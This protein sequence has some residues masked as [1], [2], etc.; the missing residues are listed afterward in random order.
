MKKR[1]RRFFQNYTKYFIIINKVKCLKNAINS[2]LNDYLPTDTTKYLNFLKVK[3]I[4][5]IKIN[6][7]LERKKDSP[8][9]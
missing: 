8:L 3:N 9:V 4:L 1:I 5:K 6:Y 2:N 7:P